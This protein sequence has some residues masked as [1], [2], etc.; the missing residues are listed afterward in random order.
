MGSPYTVKI[1][2]EPLA[3]VEIE[4]LKSEVEDRLREINREMSHYQQ[5]SELSQF[6]QAPAHQ[7]FPVSPGFAR[8]VRFSLELSER[9]DGAFDP[10]LSTIINLWGFGEKPIQPGTPTES[11]INA[12]LAKTGS[13]HLFVTAKDELVKDVSGLGINL[14]GVAKGFGVDEIVSTLK[15]HG[16]TNIYSAIAGDVRALGHNARGSVW[17]IGISVPMSNWRENDP[18]AGVVGL[19][20]QAISTSGD[21]QKFFADSQ[22]RRQGHIFDPKTG[23]PVQHNV[24]SVSVVAADSMAADG[25]ST[26]LFVLGP[27]AGLKFIETITNASALF[28]LRESENRYRQIRSSRFPPVTQ[29]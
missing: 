4:K 17:Q 2:G 10:T 8:V 12:A 22:G 21:Y 23:H 27:E 25:L 9:S 1:V 5:D 24:G 20:N 11:E 3:P 29:P 15:R 14:G 26:T 18:M 13:K 28:I 7:P 19:S 16:F 6:N